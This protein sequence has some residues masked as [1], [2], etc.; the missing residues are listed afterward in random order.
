MKDQKYYLV[1]N[2][3]VI[4]DNLSREDAYYLADEYSLA[5]GSSVNIKKHI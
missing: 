5:F 4:E 1:W 3:E 2:G